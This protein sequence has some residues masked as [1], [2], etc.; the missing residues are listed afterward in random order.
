MLQHCFD[1]FTTLLTRFMP[2]G[3]KEDRR[4]SVYAISAHLMQATFGLGKFGITNYYI[5]HRFR[6]SSEIRPEIFTAPVKT[7][8]T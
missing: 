2:T 8:S 6:K 7:I 5:L 3:L 1:I 4:K